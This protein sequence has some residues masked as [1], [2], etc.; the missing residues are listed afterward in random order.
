MFG[1]FV[2]DS[3]RSNLRGS[4]FKIFVGWACPQ[5]PLVGMYAFAH[6]CAFARYFHPA[7][8]LFPPLPPTQNL[9]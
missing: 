1:K 4:K 2:P 6:E 9:V 7:T 5:A 8:I 3:I